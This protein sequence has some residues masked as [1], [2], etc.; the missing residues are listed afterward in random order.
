MATVVQ[1]NQGLATYILDHLRNRIER[2]DAEFR[3]FAHIFLNQVF[4]SDVYEQMLY[5]LPDPSL[6]WS[7]NE[8]H[9]GRGDGG[10]VRSLFELTTDRIAELHWE[11]REFWREVTGALTAPEL[12][13]IMFAKLAPDLAFR[14][15]VQECNVTNLAGFTRPTLYRETDGYEIPPHPDTRRK[16]VTMQLY[17]PVDDTQLELGTALYRRKLSAWPFGNW[18]SRFTKVKQFEFRPNSGYAFVVNNTLTRKSWHGR[19]Q[20]PPSC[21][22]R[23]TLLNTFYETPRA[24]F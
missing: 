10:V 12:K 3:P 13:G 9:Y 2:T 5:H 19:E 4:P 16:V 20:L 8:K 22:V 6:Y 23:N 24:G 11:S 17:L 21:G 1:A 14:Y 7:A 18:R 15:S